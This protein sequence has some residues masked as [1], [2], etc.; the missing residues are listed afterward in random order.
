MDLSEIRRVALREWQPM[1]SAPFDGSPVTVL[2]EDGTIEDEV[3][4]SFVRY[5]DAP[6]G[7]CGPGWVSTVAGNLPVDDPIAWM[8][9]L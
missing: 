2:Y 3:Y 4:W 7:S 5:V 6:Y 9:P 8:E 1:D